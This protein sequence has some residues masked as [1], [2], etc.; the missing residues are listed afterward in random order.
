MATRPGTRGEAVAAFTRAV[1]KLEKEYL[2]R[3]PEDARTFFVEDLIIVRLRGILTPAEQ[4]LAKSDSGRELVKESR[5]RLFDTARVREQIADFTRAIIGCEIVS[6]HT[7]VSTR[8]GE[9][10]IVLTV[11]HDLDASFQDR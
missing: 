6:L 1:I 3:G 2:G 4:E 7:D 10:L 11:D 5:R 8:T 9:R